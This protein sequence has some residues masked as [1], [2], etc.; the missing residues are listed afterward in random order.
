[1][2][3]GRCVDFLATFCLCF[4]D[5]RGPRQ[6]VDLKTFSLS[7]FFPTTLEEGFGDSNCGAL[8]S[9]CPVLSSR[10]WPRI[11][12]ERERDFMHYCFPELDRAGLLGDSTRSGIKYSRE[13]WVL[14]CT[15]LV[16]LA[17]LIIF[18]DIEFIQ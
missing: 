10:K 15:V 9:V 13:V 1:M 4:S 14:L 7:S 8:L 5:A 17:A 11:V 3:K 12:P 6:V 16:I 2:P 18:I